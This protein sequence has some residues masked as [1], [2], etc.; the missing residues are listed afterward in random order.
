[1]DDDDDDDDEEGALSSSSNHRHKG[2]VRCLAQVKIPFVK[3]SDAIADELL[4]F[5]SGGDDGT[6]K[7]WKVE[8]K[9][10]SEVLSS[11][12]SLGITSHQR[13]QSYR[14]R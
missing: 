2:A 11:S 5:A 14:S 12:R 9:K 8:E 3:N 1:M 4:L 10:V 7:L 13:L 6:T